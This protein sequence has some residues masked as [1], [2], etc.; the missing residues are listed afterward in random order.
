MTWTPSCTFGNADRSHGP[1]TTIPILPELNRL[2]YAESVGLRGIRVDDPNDVGPA[3]EA[4][5]TSDRPVVIDAV[6]DP[7]V[8]P[9]PPHITFTQAVN[10]AHAVAHGDSGR[11]GMITQAIR[12]RAQQLVPGR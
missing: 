6:T 9:L 7:E 3:W 5:L 12:Q 8:P 4:A 1:V 10:F 11:R 2:A